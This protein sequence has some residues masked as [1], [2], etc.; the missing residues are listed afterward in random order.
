VGD[1]KFLPNL[2]GKPKGSRPFERFKRRWKDTEIHLKH[3]GC[4]NVLWI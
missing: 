4:E 2:I 3:A 1:E